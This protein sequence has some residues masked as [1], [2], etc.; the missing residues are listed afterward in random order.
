MKEVL[1]GGGSCGWW[2]KAGSREE[3]GA[4]VPPSAPASTFA[5]FFLKPGR[6]I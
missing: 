2:Q 4:L 1:V 5:A 3:A 6:R